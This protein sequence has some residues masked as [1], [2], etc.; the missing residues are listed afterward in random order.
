M[1]DLWEKWRRM[2]C[3]EILTAVNASFYGGFVLMLLCLLLASGGE[4]P[5]WL[6]AMGLL[7]FLGCAFGI[8]LAC[9]RLRCP[10]CGASLMLGGRIP[11]RLPNFCP[12]CGKPL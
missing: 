1:K 5:G 4:T 2:G 9:T 3:R 6:I 10:H 12:K 7:G 11:T 8:L